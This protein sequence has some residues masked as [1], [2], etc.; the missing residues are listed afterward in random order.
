MEDRFKE[1]SNFLGS[2]KFLMGD[3]ITIADFVMHDPITWNQCLDENLIKKFPN[4]LEY[5]NRFQ[6]EPKIKEFLEG[7]KYFNQFFLTL[8]SWPGGK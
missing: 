4:I 5:V 3:K 8:A 7:P 6:N 2:K 1:L